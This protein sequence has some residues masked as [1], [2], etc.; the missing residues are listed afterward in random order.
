MEVVRREGPAVS[1]DRIAREAGVTKPIVYRA[2]GDREGLTAAVAERF[3]SSIASALE[4]A[5]ATAP[6]DRARVSGAV[7]AY[8]SFIEREPAIVRFLIHRSIGEVDASGVAV[9][10]FVG[11]VAGLVASAL[12]EALRERRLDSG[13]AEPW[14]FAIVGAVHLAGDWWLSRRTMPRERLVEYLTAL[15]WDGM[16]VAAVAPG[17]RPDGKDG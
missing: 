7:D 13:A 12:G 10:D 14:A 9:S 15:V 1:M 5:I 2:F 6:D 11:R 3:A 4:E 8:L 17:A 16:N